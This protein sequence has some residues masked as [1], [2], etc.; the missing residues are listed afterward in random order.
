M[1]KLSTSE[2][3]D[4]KEV[5]SS[6]FFYVAALA[7]TFLLIATVYVDVCSALGL[8]TF[9]S[10]M[11]LIPFMGLIPIS[12]IFFA[13]SWSIDNRQEK[14]LFERIRKNKETGAMGNLQVA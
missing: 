3:V 7:L 4:S 13:I 12:G 5:L 1:E 8:E 10:K 14:A 6:I 2:K 11:D 9:S